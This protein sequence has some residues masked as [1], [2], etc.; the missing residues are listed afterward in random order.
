MTDNHNQPESG[1]SEI[2]V[3][4]NGDNTLVA[5]LAMHSQLARDV[6]YLYGENHKQR[7]NQKLE[8]NS[9]KFR[10]IKALLKIPQMEAEIE[11]NQANTT[12]HHIL[13]EID[14]QESEE[15]DTDPGNSTLNRIY[16]FHSQLKGELIQ[17]LRENQERR[18]RQ[19]LEGIRVTDRS[20]KALLKIPQMEAE[21]ARLQRENDRLKTEGLVKVS[22]CHENGISSD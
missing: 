5:I 10:T 11:L 12:Y 20:L 13:P 6:V 22:M 4:L 1:I 14:I 17:I 2:E 16:G 9:K 7:T 19:H 15:V 21:L 8:G 3:D 18:K